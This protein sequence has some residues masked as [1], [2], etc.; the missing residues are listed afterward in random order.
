MEENL[1]SSEATIYVLP[2]CKCNKII[3]LDS[4]LQWHLTSFNKRSVEHQQLPNPLTYI[5]ITQM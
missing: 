1:K 3:E 4:D 2:V 5:I